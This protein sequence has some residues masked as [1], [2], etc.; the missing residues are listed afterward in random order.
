[1]DFKKIEQRIEKATKKA[2]IE[3]FEKHKEEEIYSFSLYSDE[4]AMTVCPSTNTIDFLK[5][6]NEKEKEELPYYKFEPAEWKYEM[7][8]AD[9]DFN[10]I[11]KNLR[12]ELEKN[13][14]LD[15]DEYNEKWFLKFQKDL[16]QTCI[17]ILKKLKKEDFFKKITGRDIF[18]IF[19]VSEFEFEKKKIESMIT[20]LNDNEYR[21]EY[22]EW[23]KTWSE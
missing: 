14:F 18:I 22:L 6:L 9:E 19:S 2:F 12:E 17:N 1:M 11:C 20:E 7:V 10:E 3:M 4:G 16:Y 8:G 5:N 13:E 15:N 23:M 21:I